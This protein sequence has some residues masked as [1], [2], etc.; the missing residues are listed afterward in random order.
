MA[1]MNRTGA[2]LKEKA[3]HHIEVCLAVERQAESILRKRNQPASEWDVYVATHRRGGLVPVYGPVEQET[4]ETFWSIIIWTSTR[5]AGRRRK[6]LM[7]P[8]LVITCGH[9]VAWVIEVKWGAFEG[10]SDT[11]MDSR[12]LGRELGKIWRT[13][14][15]IG[16]GVECC[17]RGPVVGDGKYVE[18]RKRRPVSRFVIDNTTEFALVSDFRNIRRVLGA[19]PYNETVRLLDHHKRTCAYATVGEPTGDIRSFTKIIS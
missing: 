13:R 7:Q 18:A 10:C 5:S 12:T 4:G 2:F 6:S 17:I 16:E 3:R 11:D 14:K 8:D 1:D 19:G 15:A 9:R